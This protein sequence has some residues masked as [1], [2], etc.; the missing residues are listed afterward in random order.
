[1]T[2]FET[3]EWVLTVQVRRDRRVNWTEFKVRGD[4]LKLRYTIVTGSL[5]CHFFFSSLRLRLIRALSKEGAY[6]RAAENA[7]RK[8][9]GARTREDEDR[10]SGNAGLSENEIF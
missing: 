3:I 8:T 9:G 5:I 6:D 2:R 1:M 7:K 10:S 4:H